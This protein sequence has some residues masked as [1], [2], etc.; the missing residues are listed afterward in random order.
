MA[1]SASPPYDGDEGESP[2]KRLVHLLERHGL[3]DSLRDILQSI[4]ARRQGS[5]RET[6][7]AVL[8]ELLDGQPA[9]TEQ[10][11]E[12]ARREWQG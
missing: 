2:A 8:N 6:R 1:Q 7:I 9:L 3:E 11:L 5:Q 10:E 12:Q 4:E